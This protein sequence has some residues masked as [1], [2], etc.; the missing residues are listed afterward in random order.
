M[1]ALESCSIDLTAHERLLYAPQIGQT[2]LHVAVREKQVDC[3]RLILQA[4][5]DNPEAFG[6]WLTAATK[7]REI[8]T[9]KFFDAAR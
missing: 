5:K 1:H 3:V 8:G 9:V 6:G 7:V 4:A 2:P